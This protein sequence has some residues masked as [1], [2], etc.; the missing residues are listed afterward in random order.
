MGH[1]ISSQEI[2]VDPKKI[3]AV[4]NWEAPTNISE[5][6]SFLGLAGY[7]RRFV[8]GFSILAAPIT[9]L[10]R[11]DVKFQWDGQC[12]RAFEKLKQWFTSAPV[13]TLPSA[14]EDL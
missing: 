3:E 11:K 2:Q 5:V 8:E 14:E 1:V 13:L 6:R 10:L 12:Q 9:K 7:Y 4:L